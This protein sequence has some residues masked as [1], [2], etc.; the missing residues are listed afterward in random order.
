MIEDLAVAKAATFYKARKK[1]SDK[2]VETAFTTLRATY[3]AK[4][5][6]IFKHTREVL[7]DARW[8]AICFMFETPP[9]FLDNTSGVRETLCGYLMLVEY[10]NHVSVFSSRISLPAA[11]KSTHFA[12]VPISRVEGVI[13]TE[14]A[15]FHKM[16]MRNMSVSQY[17]MHNKTLEAP[18]LA[19]VVGPAGSRRYAP[20]TYSVTTAGVQSTAT[21][22]TGRIGVRSDR[23]GQPELVEFAIG[24]IDA[25]RAEPAD[26]SPFIRT[27]ARPMSLADALS[28]S[29][30]ITLAIDTNKLTD[31]VIGDNAMIRLVRVGDEVVALTAAELGDLAAELDHALTIENG[32]KRRSAKLPGTNDDA[33]AISLNKSRIALRALTL[34][35]ADEI[36]IETLEK[37]L[38]GDPDRRSLHQYLDEEN[39]FVVLFDDVRLSYIDGQVFRDET[40]LDGGESFLRYLHADA[41]LQ[42]VTGEKGNF[43]TGQ[44]A[45]DATSTFGAV[46]DHI[47]A[48]DTTLVCD[49]L[50]DEWADFVGIKEIGGLT[51]IS[52]YHAKHGAL[53]VSAASFHVSVSQAIKNLGNMSFP[54][55]RMAAKIQ[56]WGGTYNGPGQATQIPRTVRSNGANLADTFASA[57]T[58]PDALRRAVI[59]TSS[60]SKQ[61]VADAFVAIQVGQRP[62]HTFVQLYWLLQSFFSACT[63]V[64]ATG[65]VVCQP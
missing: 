3:G 44:T 31:A 22:G 21:P 30:P 55:E 16:R 46:I 12:P 54:E 53:E 24:V 47:A 56:G 41:S 9:A 20:Q 35:G 65:S 17:V 33:A 28:S 7:R 5:H 32:G 34:G 63:E 38:G 62:S 51:Q 40:M 39:A 25:L 18:N 11:F 60:L 42:A 57:R 50:G 29:Q 8:S 4:A 26:V 61:A 10:E 27:F 23:V 6:N 59:V 49:D 64:G 37:P 13:A 45:F 48:T 19:N 15:V 1:L 14:N 36:Q 43:V 58:A 52:F 2:A